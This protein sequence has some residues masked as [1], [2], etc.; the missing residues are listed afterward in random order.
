MNWDAVGAVAE[1]LSSVGV[2][3]TLVYIAVQVR[4]AKRSNLI[5]ASADLTNQI[6]G[7]IIDNEHLAEVIAKINVQ[8]G[9]Q[10][11]Q[12]Q[13]AID[14]WGLSARDAEIWAR[15]WGTVWRGFQSRFAAGSLDETTLQLFLEN[16]Q[17]RLYVKATKRTY[18]PPFVRFIEGCYPGIF[19]DAGDA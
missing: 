14:E 8:T 17:A 13:A 15:Y 3:A 2:L 1:L 11:P 12:A 19:D 10:L 16:P 6:A 7:R 18:S 5:N 9:H 4:D